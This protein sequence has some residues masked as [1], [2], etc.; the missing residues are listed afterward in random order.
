MQRVLRWMSWPAAGGSLALAGVGIAGIVLVVLPF[1]ANGHMPGEMGDPRFND[2]VLEHTYLWLVGRMPSFWNAPIFYPLPMTIAFSDNH[3]GTAF[4]YWLLRGAGFDRYDAYRGWFVLAY[5]VNFA[6]AAYVLRRLGHRRVGT[7]LG[8]FL[9][10]FAL[11][12][13]AQVDHAQLNYRFA[14]PLAVLALVQFRRAPKLAA[15]LSLEFWTV[16]QFY[17]SIYLGYFLCLLLGAAMLAFALP[18]AL[19]QERRAAV[20]LWPR[21]ALAAWRKASPRQRGGFALGTVTFAA[22]LAGLLYPYLQVSRLYGFSHGWREISEAMP[23]L[24]SYFYND[25]SRLWAFPPLGIPVSSVI[26]EQRLFIGFAAP[27]T[28]LLAVALRAGGRAVLDPLFATM[29]LAL[30]L[31]FLATLSIHDV[32]VYRLLTL[33]PGVNAVR[34]VSRIIFVMLFPIALLLAGAVDAISTTRW[35][36]PA[37]I[38]VLVPLAA[39][40]VLECSAIVPERS[41]E[42]AWQDRLRRVAASLPEALPDE[43]ILLLAPRPGEE[44]TPSELDAMLLAQERGW[45]TLNGYSGNVPVAHRET[46]DCRDA[47]ADLFGAFDFLGEPGAARLQAVAPRVVR[48]GYPDCDAAWPSYRQ[49]ITPF[50]GPLP[51]DIMARTALSGI[52]LRLRRGDPVFDV[53]IENHGDRLLPAGSATTQPVEIAAQY[54]TTAQATPAGLRH[55]RWIMCGELDSDVP[56]GDALRVTIPLP[57]PPAGGPYRVVVSLFQLNVDSAWFD[58]HGMAVA[59]SRQE[60]SRDEQLHLADGAPIE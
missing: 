21:A 54:V 39:L 46:G 20:R 41:T 53:V 35:P 25:Q 38:A 14:V 32:S 56:A 29:A 1:V 17:C 26:T 47:A 5:A 22:L 16:W 44:K 57:P 33:V 36:R 7:A 9:F 18:F 11:P 52:D 48:V 6:S 51:T 31:L 15:L 2:Y 40:L 34:M 42:A 12:V 8:A 60:I 37:V 10:A 50:A 59:I 30:A 4:S 55:I 58:D 24:G 13:T 28:I 3:I 45:S 23:R 19:Q 49:H 27:L 43:P